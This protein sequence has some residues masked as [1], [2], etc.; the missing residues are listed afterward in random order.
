MI[1]PA[2]RS[3]FVNGVAAW[4]WF[5]LRGERERF[6]NPAPGAVQC[7]QGWKPARTTSLVL[8][9]KD[10]PL[11]QAARRSWNCAF[12]GD[13]MDASRGPFFDN[14]FDPSP[15]TSGPTR[16]RSGFPL[17][18]RSARRVGRGLRRLR[19]E[20]RRAVRLG[21]D[22]AF[23]CGR[24]V[25]FELVERGRRD[26]L[27]YQRLA[28]QRCRARGRVAKLEARCSPSETI[29][30]PV[31]AMRAM[32]SRQASSWARASVARSIRPASN[33][34]KACCRCAGRGSEPTGS[35]RNVIRETSEG[36]GTNPG[37]G[38][39]RRRVPSHGEDQAPAE[40]PK[41]R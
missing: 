39:A 4:D 3:V 8:S 20:G 10:L 2:S 1:V 22:A 34:A 5:M 15:P 28:R 16:Y 21:A 41:Q 11:G 19:A 30:E 27:R 26:R 31:A 33:S 37:D 12:R 32:R 18:V 17:A 38:A 23:E 9:K 40:A 35:V 24:A 7:A 14:A 25:P 6:A 36:R 13:I 29:G